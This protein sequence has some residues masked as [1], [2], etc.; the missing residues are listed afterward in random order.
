MFDSELKIVSTIYQLIK[1]IYLLIDGRFL[2][3]R[4]PETL[5]ATD[6]QGRTPLHYAAL[7]KDNRNYYN[8][9]LSLG[10]DKTVKDKVN[11]DISLGFICFS[12]V[13]F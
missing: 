11:P 2:A 7:L 12:V 6:A 3:S 4:F 13:L 5:Q 9:L 1:N 8:M 10:A